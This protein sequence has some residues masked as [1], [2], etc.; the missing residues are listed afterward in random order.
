MNSYFVGVRMDSQ[1]NSE[2]EK[3]EPAKTASAKVLEGS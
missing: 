3:F 2:K 1:A